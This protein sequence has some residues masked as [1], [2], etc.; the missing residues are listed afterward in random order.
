MLN[1]VSVKTK[2]LVLL[3]TPLVL[4]AATAVY[5]MEMN[6]SNTQKLKESLYSVTNRATALVLNA[7]RDMYQTL[8]AY[9]QLSSPFVS[10]ADKE[11][12]KADFAENVEQTNERISQALQ[13]V[14]EQ[15]VAHLTHPDSGRSISE[16]IAE[17]DRLFNEWAGLA[18]SQFQTGEYTVE[19]ETE[20]LREFDEARANIN[21]FG[22]ILEAY[23]LQVIESVTEENSR[24]TLFTSIVLVVQWVVLIALGLFVI[25]QLSRTV[26]LVHTRT[27]QVADGDLSYSPQ[28]RYAK[29]ELGQI[30]FSVDGMIGKMRELIGAI[31]DNSRQVAAASDDLARSARES[32]DVSAHVAE[33]IQ[34][35]T[36]L[37]ES[38]SEMAREANVAMEEMAVGVHR[39]AE[40]T[41][42]ISDHSRQTNERA[43]EGTELLAALKGQMEQVAETIGHLSRSVAVLSAKSDRIGEFTEKMTAIANQ[44]GILSLNASIEASRAGEHGRGFAVVAQEIRKLAAVSLESA[45]SIGELTE[46]TRREIALVSAYMQATVAGSEQGASALEE[47]AHGYAVIVES[48]KQVGQ[49]LHDTSAVTEQMSAS[50]EEVSASMEQSSSSAREIA[51]KA[52]N[53][54]A[55]T[56]EQLALVENISSASER[57]Q[58]I[59]NELDRSVRYFRL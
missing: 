55:A 1:S 12:A 49:Q 43:D 14:T 31:A 47:M 29:D 56:E 53:V 32:A 46:D 19:K 44:T 33:N 40:S 22:E 51:G 4:F 48:I 35:V 37:V 10:P 36:A 30:L 23:A 27:K 6:S 42:V 34:E 11:K 24:T 5:L 28:A 38:Q 15:E 57:L 59:V 9:H 52:Q 58:S 25:R 18:E 13:I 3:F 20:L 50:S 26:A 8:A 7:D 54:S 17:M 39:I 16:T 41:N 45:Q 21:D 2:L